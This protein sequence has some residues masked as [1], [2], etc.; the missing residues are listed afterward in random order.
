MDELFAEQNQDRLVED[1]S[2]EATEFIE[3]GDYINAQ[4][5]IEQVKR[6]DVTVGEQLQNELKAAQQSEHE[7]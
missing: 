2:I 3:V 1:L 4:S 6:L 5:L 7:Y